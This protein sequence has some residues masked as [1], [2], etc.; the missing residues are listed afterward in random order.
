MKKMILSLIVGG[1]MFSE[2][3]A[4]APKLNLHAGLGPKLST[5]GVGLT[6]RVWMFDRFGASINCTRSRDGDQE[7]GELLIHYKAVEVPFVQPYA[8][9]GLGVQRINIEDMTPPLY[10]EPVPVF[11]GGIGGE[12]LLGSQKSHGIS[13]EAAYRSGAV[14]YRV[15]SSKG[16]GESSVSF[17]SDQVRELKHFSVGLLYHFYFVPWA[18]KN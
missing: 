2:A 15:R 12:L 3:L 8:I 16:L 9:L 5:E 1:M 14:S 6:A 17:T 7:G 4:A 11:V 13:L 10:N 18:G